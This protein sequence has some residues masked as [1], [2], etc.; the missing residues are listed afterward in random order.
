MPFRSY[1][2]CS[3]TPHFVLRKDLEDPAVIDRHTRDSN[4]N[5][6][7]MRVALEAGSGE[8]AIMEAETIGREYG[9]E[10]TPA[11]LLAQQLVTGLFPEGERAFIGV[12]RVAVLVRSLRDEFKYPVFL[13]ADHTHS[14]EKAL[15]AVKDGF[16][17][18]VFD[19]SSLAFEENVRETRKALEAIKAIEP[20]ILVEGEVDIGTGSQIH[21]ETPDLIKGLT[22]VEE[23][24]QFVEATGVG[25]LA[26]AVGTMHGISKGSRRLRVRS[27]F[28]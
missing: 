12:R 7:A 21:E 25:I 5:L 27:K 26:S 9:V 4:V 1:T 2:K 28:L 10:G 23:A 24:K 16:D 15:E 20:S 3:S 6:A 13:N 19:A 22:S 14:L 18:I 8:E 17:M 11:W